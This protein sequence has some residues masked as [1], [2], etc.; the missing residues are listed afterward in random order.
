MLSEKTDGVVVRSMRSSKGCRQ[1][2]PYHA[3]HP[4]IST[5]SIEPSVPGLVRDQWSGGCFQ[6]AA[7]M[8]AMSEVFMVR[9]PRGMSLQLQPRK[10][11]GPRL[12]LLTDSS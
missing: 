4:C 9:G 6:R 3:R 7:G 1:V 8:R 11:L 5:K 2:Y 10:K 12:A